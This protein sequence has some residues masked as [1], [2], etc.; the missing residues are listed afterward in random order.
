MFYKIL[1]TVRG[2]EEPQSNGL[3]FPSKEE[4]EAFARQMYSPPLSVKDWT[5]E[6]ETGIPNYTFKNGILEHL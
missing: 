4:A 3:R 1:I 6:G 2:K 5:V